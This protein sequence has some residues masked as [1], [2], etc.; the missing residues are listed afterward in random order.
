MSEKIEGIEQ[1]DVEQLKQW[2]KNNHSAPYFIDIREPAEY[3]EGHIPGV[4]LLPMQQIPEAAESMKKDESY[5]LICRSGSR[6]QH[7]AHY[8]K[9]NGFGQ[10]KNF[11]G[12]ML[13]WDE[14]L[15]TGMENPLEN[16]NDLYKK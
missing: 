15:Q 5:V 10:V 4:P 6:S 1:I 8:L 14:E 12:G 11:S 16:I 2:Y 13:T 7:A 3:V 9:E